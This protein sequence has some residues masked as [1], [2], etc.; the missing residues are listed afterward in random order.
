[1]GPAVSGAWLC[2]GSSHWMV[3]GRKRGAREGVCSQE[4]TWAVTAIQVT[5]MT[6]DEL[7]VRP[8]VHLL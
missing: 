7:S 5:M 1:M 3:R 8:C 6:A 2:R 4:V